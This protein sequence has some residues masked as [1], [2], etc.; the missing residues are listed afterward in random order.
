MRISDFDR[1]LLSTLENANTALRTNIVS[2]LSGN[3]RVLHGKHFKFFDVRNS[4]LSETIRHHK[5]G[6][7]VRAVTDLGHKKL[8]LKSAADTIVDTFGLSPVGLN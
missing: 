3:R 1:K 5:L 4:N 6:S 2:D 8:A 7:I